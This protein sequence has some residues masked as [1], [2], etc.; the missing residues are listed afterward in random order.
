MPIF[1]SAAAYAGALHLWHQYALAQSNPRAGIA[2]EYGLH[3]DTETMY[4]PGGL[5][6]QADEVAG[7]V[8]G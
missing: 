7:V 2:D 6:V 5:L 1:P 3:V 4:R 8:H